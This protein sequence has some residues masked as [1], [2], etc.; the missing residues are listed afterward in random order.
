MCKARE[1][2][3]FRQ[4]PFLGY[5]AKAGSTEKRMSMPYVLRERRLALLAAGLRTVGVGAGR[6]GF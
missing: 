5:F 3:C 6:A 2:A 1:V 4:L